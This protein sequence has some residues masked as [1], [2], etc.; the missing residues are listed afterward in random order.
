MRTSTPRCG[1]TSGSHMR[2]NDSLAAGPAADSRPSSNGSTPTSSFPP[3]RFAGLVW[4]CLAPPPPS[5][6]PAGAPGL[7]RPDRPDGGFTILVACGSYSFGDVVDTITEVLG[8]SAAARVG[9]A[10]GGDTALHA[11][12]RRH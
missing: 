4:P 9:A 3:F 5:H 1:D 10:G 8:A 6:A 12:L 2:P 11:R 7:P